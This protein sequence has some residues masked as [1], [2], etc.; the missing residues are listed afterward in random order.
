MAKMHHNIAYYVICM[1]VYYVVL[2]VFLASPVG[3]YMI[4]F[5]VNAHI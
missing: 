5:A 1:Y 4:S 2:C 3:E